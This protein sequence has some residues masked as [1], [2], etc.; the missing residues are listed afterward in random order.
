[1]RKFRVGQFI[2][3][4]TLLSLVLI[5]LFSRFAPFIH[6]FLFPH[7][8]EAENQTYMLG[9]LI[10]FFC[11]ILMYPLIKTKS[12][13]NLFVTNKVILFTLIFLDSLILIIAY[14][15]SQY[16]LHSK[17]LQDTLKLFMIFHTEDLST[18]D[19]LV[20]EIVSI[21]VFTFLVAKIV[22]KPAARVIFHTIAVAIIL[23]LTLGMSNLNLFDY[24]NYAGPINDLILGKPLLTYRSSY[25]FAPI[26][27]LSL[28]FNYI[29]LTS[30]YLTFEIAVINAFGFLLFYLLN[31]KIFKDLRWATVVTVSSIFV[32]HL[33]ADRPTYQIPQQT[34]IRLGMWIFVALALSYNAFLRKKFGKVS[35]Y[36][37]AFLVVVC[38]FWSADFGLYIFLAYCLYLLVLSLHQ[39]IIVFTI[40]YL[41]RL[42]KLSAILSIIFI[43]INFIYL[44]SYRSFPMWGEYYFAV[45]KY[46]SSGSMVL[47]FPDIPFIFVYI[48]VLLLV[49]CYLILVEKEKGELD[50]SQKSVL[51]TACVGLI[52]FNYFLGRP[53]PSF[54][55]VLSLPF[56]VCTYYLLKI[57]LNS[58][59]RISKVLLFGIIFFIATF[60]SVPGT[61]LAYQGLKTLEI[62]NPYQ[63]IRILEHKRPEI[64]D[65][66]YWVGPTAEE[67]R[68]KYNSEIRAGNLTLLSF[69][70]TWLLVILHTTNRAGINCLVCY[71]FPGEDLGFIVE[72]IR[73]SS[74]RYLFVD[75]NRNIAKGRVEHLFSKIADQYT[76][77]E[78]IGFIDVYKRK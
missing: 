57:I 76:Y 32:Q 52:T 60:F 72:N 8:A 17:N 74:S 65:E 43:L 41:R 77:I 50:D 51:F 2:I 37:P 47:P 34:F 39:Q 5:Y 12:E 29:P 16:V 23:Y 35:N 56:I 20:G 63:T 3:F 75:T 44:I 78:T 69:W 53:A 26:L 9:L 25:G 54:L 11:Q 30:I 46:Q 1:M 42:L 33:V 66:Y 24:S 70:D 14:F 21:A 64:N 28:I 19:F 4:N 13:K 38:F 27:F 6:R 71:Y 31:N 40:I 68:N 58:F 15:G 22:F 48:I 36:V 49:V 55:N 18:R 10:F 7:L 59:Q 61:L 73:N 62:A 67:L 45:Y